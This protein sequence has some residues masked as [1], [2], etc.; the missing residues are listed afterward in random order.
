MDTWWMYH[1]THLLGEEILY[2]VPPYSRMETYFSP[3]WRRLHGNAFKLLLCYSV[4]AIPVILG[5]ITPRDVTDPLEAPLKTVT[6][7]NTAIGSQIPLVSDKSTLILGGMFLFLDTVYATWIPR[8]KGLAFTYVS[9]HF[10]CNTI[11]LLGQA[12]IKKKTLEPCP[13]G[14]IN[15]SPEKLITKSD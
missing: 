3:A 11:A 7:L 14:C 1:P 8:W 12:E 15:L 4:K 6:P 5:S 2:P 13:T 9:N 10:T